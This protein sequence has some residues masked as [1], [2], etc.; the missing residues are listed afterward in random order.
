MVEDKPSYQR[1]ARWMERRGTITMF[2]MSTIPNP[3]F[4]V[5]GLAAGAVRMPMKRFFFAVWGGKVLKDTWLAAL[6]SAGVTI[7]TNWV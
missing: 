6:A 3:L 5:A 2:L 1:I 4:D 7:F